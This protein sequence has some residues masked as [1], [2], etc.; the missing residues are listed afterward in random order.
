MEKNAPKYTAFLRKYVPIQWPEPQSSEEDHK[1]EESCVDEPITITL[2]KEELAES[3]QNL[4]ET[5]EEEDKDSIDGIA[6]SHVLEVLTA[7]REMLEKEEE[8]MMNAVCPVTKED[9]AYKPEEECEKP[10]EEEK[11]EVKE[12]EEEEWH[13]GGLKWILESEPEEEEKPCEC[14]EEKCDVCEKEKPCEKC[15]EEKE[16]EKP[17]EC[18]CGE[19]VCE[20]CEKPK[21]EKCEEEKEEKKE[22]E[23]EEE[24][25]CET[26][27]ETTNEKCEEEWHL[28]T[29]QWVFEEHTPEKPGIDWTSVALLL[30]RAKQ[31]LIPQTH[32][33]DTPVETP[34]ETPAETPIDWNHVQE[35]IEEAKSLLANETEAPTAEDAIK[36]Q[37][38]KEQENKEQE[39]KEQESKEQEN[40]DRELIAELTEKVSQL[41]EELKKKSMEESK[42]VYEVMKEQRD[43]ILAKGE[44]RVRAKEEELRAALTKQMNE[45][46]EAA[47]SEVLNTYKKEVKKEQDYYIEKLDDFVYAKEMAIKG[48]FLAEEE[49]LNEKWSERLTKEIENV[50][51]EAEEE[52]QEKEKEVASLQS[53]VSELVEELKKQEAVLRHAI[54]VQEYQELLMSIQSQLLRHEGIDKELAQLVGLRR[55]GS[56]LGGEG[57]GRPDYGASDQPRP[58][59]HREGGRA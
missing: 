54:R 23:K 37:E 46:K 52:K 13:V 27:K 35:V 26:C 3:I 56:G 42:H 33:V 16:E 39:N 53:S 51:E 21:C 24:K 47:V 31:L 22:E 38:N 12:K 4:L 50:R 40:K 2:K 59:S 44:E 55:A 19:E 18:E 9:F 17:C 29:A 8:E 45:E 5:M 32:T 28:S 7:A 14:E 11:K 30:R 1:E 15:E 25:P 41:E 36:E 20:V 43:A 6:L 10:C 57:G 49:K 34:I 58:A 48:H